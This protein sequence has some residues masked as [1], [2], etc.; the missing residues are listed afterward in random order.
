[1]T[2]EKMCSPRQMFQ[3][4]DWPIPRTRQDRSTSWDD[5]L[6]EAERRYEDAKRLRQQEA[7]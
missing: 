7:A 6:D 4:L 3:L 1:M 5:V 2:A